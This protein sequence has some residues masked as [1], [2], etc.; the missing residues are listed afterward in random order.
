[1]ASSEGPRSAGDPTR[2]KK[3]LV[4]KIAIFGDVLGALHV[5]R[6]PA[7]GAWLSKMGDGADI[8]HE[9]LEWIECRAVGQL[10]VVLAR[11]RRPNTPRGSVGAPPGNA[12][13]GRRP[14]PSP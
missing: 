7:D 12:L 3:R 9:V 2:E 4:E 6:Q 14:A 11:D 1:M 13:D 10:Q 8:E 5:A